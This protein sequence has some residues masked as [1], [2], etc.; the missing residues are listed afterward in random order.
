VLAFSHGLGG[1]CNAYSHLLGSLASCGVICVAAEHRDQSAPVSIIRNADGSRR[2]IRYSK[3]SHEPSPEV[4]RERNV[5][6]RIR[7][8]ELELLYTALSALNKGKTMTNLA[9]GG[10]P[11]LR[12]K[13]HLAPS[14]VTWAG[15]SFGAATMVQFVKSIFWHQALPKANGKASGESQGGSKFEPLYIPAENSHLKSQITPNSPLVLL[16]L[17]TMP[18]RSETTQWLWEKPLPCYASDGPP[19]NNVLGIMSDQ[20]YQWTTL[21]ERQKALLSSKPADHGKPSMSSGGVSAGPRLFYAPNTAHLS[22]SDFGVLFPWATKKW[23]KAEE[24]E[25]T[26]L[27]NTR[28]ILQ[29]LRENGILVESIKMGEEAEGDELTLDDSSILADH[30]NIQGW[31]SVAID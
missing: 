14:K 18:L 12:G 7:L 8:W 26:L 2:S 15:H 11:S 21:L 22:Q 29:L 19:K 28:A 10:V 6:L 4:L 13:L 1:S 5:Q 25:R 17:W 16:D 30:G 24:P 23:L 3:I 31:A 20:F 27:L 9:E